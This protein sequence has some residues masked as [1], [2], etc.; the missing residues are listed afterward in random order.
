MVIDFTNVSGNITMRNDALKPLPVGD[1]VN[2]DGDGQ[3]MRFVIK[4]NDTASTTPTE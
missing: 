1:P 3:I 4:Q 2:P